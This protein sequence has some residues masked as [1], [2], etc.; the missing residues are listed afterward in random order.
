M[1]IFQRSKTNLVCLMAD[2]G[3]YGFAPSAAS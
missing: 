3:S 2:G 1:T